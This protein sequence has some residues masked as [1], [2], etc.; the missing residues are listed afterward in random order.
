MSTTFSMGAEP[1]VESSRKAMGTPLRIFLFGCALSVVGNILS[2]V[3]RDS[4]NPLMLLPIAAAYV[5][6]F[7]IFACWC[8]VWLRFMA[9]MWARMD[10]IF[11]PMYLAFFSAVGASFLAVVSWFRRGGTK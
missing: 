7:T 5:G 6:N 2:Y 8:W 11:S 10:T 4:G 3:F 1:N 9:R